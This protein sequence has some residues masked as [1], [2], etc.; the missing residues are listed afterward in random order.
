[1]KKCLSFLLALM[2]LL[3]A[4]AVA[5]E[6]VAFTQ[7]QELGN[8]SLQIPE[9]WTV[10]PNAKNAD[11]TDFFDTNIKKK[12]FGIIETVLTPSGEPLFQTIDGA[13]T[14]LLARVEKEKIKDYQLVTVAGCPAI[15]WTNTQ[16][17]ATVKKTYVHGLYILAQNSGLDVL[18]STRAK[19][20]DLQA[21]EFEKLLA[22]ITAVNPPVVPLSPLP[23]ILEMITGNLSLEETQVA[24]VALLGVPLPMEEGSFRIIDGVQYPIQM[25]LSDKQ[26]SVLGRIQLAR[27]LQYEKDG[28]AI[29]EFTAPPPAYEKLTIAQGAERLL[30]LADLMKQDFGDVIKAAGFTFDESRKQLEQFSLDHEPGTEELAA[31]LKAH[32][33]EGMT[34]ELY[35]GDTQKRLRMY[36][37]AAPG[38]AT[39]NGEICYEFSFE[40]NLSSVAAE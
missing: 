19:D 35:F 12:D 6:P 40:F 39:E 27:Y 15:R 18:F 22:T 30:A 36:N 28:V 4:F 7:A 21:A 11:I 9:G 23:Q 26:I 2:L 20:Q 14:L 3:P 33:G 24:L 13:N 10:Q 31:L 17:L 5:Y 38:T 34:V 37:S 29:K 16:T 1:M 25:L 32:E 8:F